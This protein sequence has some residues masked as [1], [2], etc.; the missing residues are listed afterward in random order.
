[1]NFCFHSSFVISLDLNNSKLIVRTLKKKEFKANREK[2]EQATQVVQRTEENSKLYYRGCCQRH[3]RRCSQDVH[4]SIS[5]EVLSLIWT[6]RF[7]WLSRAPP[8]CLVLFIR[9]ILLQDSLYVLHNTTFHILQS[10]TSRVEE[11]F[12]ESLCV[13]PKPLHLGLSLCP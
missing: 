9:A 2:E 1:M 6:A 13:P 8:E 4:S 10:I 3:W 7:I 12:H 11:Q 5:Q